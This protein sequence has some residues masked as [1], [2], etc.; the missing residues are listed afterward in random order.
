MGENFL[1]TFNTSGIRWKIR[2]KNDW[3]CIIIAEEFASLAQ[4]FLLELYEKDINHIKGEPS[5]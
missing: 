5:N 4:I 2:S 3:N 1:I